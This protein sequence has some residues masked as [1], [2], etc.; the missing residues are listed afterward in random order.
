MPK[1]IGD[2]KVTREGFFPLPIY[3][4]FQNEIIIKLY[5]LQMFCNK[6]IF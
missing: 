5:I 2:D 6:S 4:I 1:I 3:V